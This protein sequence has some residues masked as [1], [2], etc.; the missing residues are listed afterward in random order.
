[1]LLDLFSFDRLFPN[2]YDY[3]VPMYSSWKESED[4]GT[5]EIVVP[6]YKKDDFDLHVEDGR[7]ILN[8]NSGKKS[9]TYS[10][11]GSYSFSTY[12]VG[13]AQAEYEAGILKIEI[14][15]IPKKK[16]KQI[17]IKVS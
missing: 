10:I 14:P 9:L 16:M 15:K 4:G 17:P 8:I 5:L 3:K 11:L 7:L 6:G 12:D 1:M 2:Y 13:A